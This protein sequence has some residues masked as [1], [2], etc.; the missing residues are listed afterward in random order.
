MPDAQQN[1]QNFFLLFN[2]LFYSL[3]FT[4]KI[5]ME[6]FMAFEKIDFK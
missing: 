4:K 1:F 2:T 3:T 5:W 6:K